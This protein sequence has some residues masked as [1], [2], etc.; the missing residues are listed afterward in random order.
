MHPLV[1]DRLGHAKRISKDVLRRGL[2]QIYQDEEQFYF[3]RGQWTVLVGY[4]PPLLALFPFQGVLLNMGQEVD[5]KSWRQGAKLF[6]RVSG[7]GMKLL[8][9]SGKLSIIGHRG[10]LLIV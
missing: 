6:G 2:A 8:R 9:V 7:Q 10:A 4:V 1:D 5:S 3:Q